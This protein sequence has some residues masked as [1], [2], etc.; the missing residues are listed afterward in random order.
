MSISC[1]TL[2]DDVKREVGRGDSDELADA[3]VRAV[4]RTLSELEH[5]SDAATAFTRATGTSS[6][7]NLDENYD[8]VL[9]SGVI[10]N[11]IRMGH[12]PGDPKVAG[13][14]YQDSKQRWD[15]ALGNYCMNEDNITQSDEDNDMTRLGTVK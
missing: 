10:Y 12:R 2:Y 8:Y 9:Y 13:V 4:N 11:L 6:S 1:A 7:V 5:R 14:V 3:F 15:E